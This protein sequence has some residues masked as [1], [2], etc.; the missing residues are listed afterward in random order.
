LLV[1][2]AFNALVSELAVPFA[3]QGE[4]SAGA[5]RTAAVEAPPAR[6]PSLLE[7][8]GPAALARTASPCTSPRKPTAISPCAF[9]GCGLRRLWSFEA[10]H[11]VSSANPASLAGFFSPHIR[12]YR[13]CAVAVWPFQTMDRR[14]SYSSPLASLPDQTQKITG[15][16]PGRHFSFRKS[17][18][19]DS[20]LTI[21]AHCAPDSSSSV[22]G[23]EPAKQTER[24]L[25]SGGF[26]P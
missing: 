14:R 9:S 15:M 21:Q 23:P 8:P 26:P 16:L 25:S 11:K 4:T 13:N 3:G 5:R 17:P 1:I 7:S 2:E 22:D 19:S 18:G 24:R 6:Q 20:P 10:P 12:E